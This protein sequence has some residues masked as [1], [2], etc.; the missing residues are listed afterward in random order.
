MFQNERPMIEIRDVLVKG[1]FAEY[2]PDF[3][4]KKLG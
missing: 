1:T 3:I 2:C 4:D